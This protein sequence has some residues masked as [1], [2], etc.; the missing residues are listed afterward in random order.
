MTSPRVRPP[1]HVTSAHNPRIKEAAALRER[2]ARE[3]AGLVLVEGAREIGRALAAGFEVDALFYCPELLSTEA[4]GLVARLDRA[5]ATSVSAHVFDK[6]ALRDG[7]DGLVVTL[8]QRPVALESALAARAGR[9]PL[10]FA[11]HGIEKPGNL[12]AVLR[13]ADGVGASGVIALEG[14]SDAWSPN[15]IRAS[16][17]TVFALPPAVATTEALLA[18]GRA[19]GLR[20]YAAA[21]GT[22]ARPPWAC[23]WRGPTCI[24]LGAEAIGLPDAWLAAADARVLIPMHGIADSLNV[25]AAAAML[26]YEAL[27]Q[28][29]HT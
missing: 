27:R 17:G 19:R 1:D 9:P 4:H 28:R 18:A 11:L 3:A 8:R 5:R 22:D 26:G 29:A 13:T 6:L 7:S 21:L 20:F 16:L 15:A 12:G 2:K 25:S 23:D 14:T 24:V 10:V